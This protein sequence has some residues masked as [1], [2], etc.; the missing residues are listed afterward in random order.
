MYYNRNTK[1]RSKKNV[2]IMPSIEIQ[3]FVNTCVRNNA[4]SNAKWRGLILKSGALCVCWRWRYALGTAATGRKRRLSIVVVGRIQQ[5]IHV[6]LSKVGMGLIFLEHLVCPF[7]TLNAAEYSVYVL[8]HSGLTP[9]SID[10]T[11]KLL[12]IFRVSREDGICCG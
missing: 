8:Q 9:M 4:R 12:L 10:G 6:S 7:G 1:T 2:K 5:A 3:L 11:I